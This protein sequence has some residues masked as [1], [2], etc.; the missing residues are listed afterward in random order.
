MTHPHRNAAVELT[1]TDHTGTPLAEREVQVE[2]TRHA[3]GFGN[4]GFDLVAHANGEADD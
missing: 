3:F 2:Q 4:I 1:L